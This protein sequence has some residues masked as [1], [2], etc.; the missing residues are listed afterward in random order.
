MADEEKN[1]IAGACRG[2]SECFGKLYDSYASRMYRFIFLKIGHKGD[3]EDLLHEVFL[4]AWKSIRNYRQQDAAPF[5]SWLYQIARNRVIDYYR[6]H[7]Q[8]LSLDDMIRTDAI[9]IELMS[10]GYAMFAHAVSQKM[11]LEEVMRAL[12]F[13]P[14]EYQTILIMRYIEDLSPQEVGAVIGK[15]SGAVRVLQHRALHQLKKTIEQSH[16]QRIPHQS[17]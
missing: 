9:P 13:L 4:S 7:K 15:T 3:A 17:A 12:K 5:T 10:G 1:L 11:E 16:E 6:T 14:D 2:D 8:A